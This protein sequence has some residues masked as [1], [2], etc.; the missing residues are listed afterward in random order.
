[1]E[2]LISVL[3]PVYNGM[4]LIKASIDSLLNQT[5]SNWEC[6]VVNDGSTDGTMEYLNSITDS[7]FRIHHFKDNKGRPEARQKTLELA[8]GEFIAMLDAEDLYS[9]DKL[10]DQVS[11]LLKNEGIALVSSVMCSFGTKSDIVRKRGNRNQTIISFDGK[12]FPNH[13][14]SMLRAEIAKKISYNP[15]MKYGQDQDFLESYLRGRK[16][17]ELPQIHY[18]YSEFDSVTKKKINKTYKLNFVKYLNN[19]CYKTA[20]AYSLKYV[21]SIF[22]T[23]FI[24]IQAILEKRGTSLTNTELMQYDRECKAIV[25]NALNNKNN[26]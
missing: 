20:F 23:P 9:K 22:I 2:P 19:R 16:Y 7:R 24:P 1:M 6:I 3:M 18:Y 26:R 13:A 10:R 11:Y 17:A 5:Y 8:T 21:Y 25:Q 4:P 12:N 15:M 14:S